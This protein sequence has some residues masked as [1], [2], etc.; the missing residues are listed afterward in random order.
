MWTWHL[1]S[2]SPRTIYCVRTKEPNSPAR[3]GEETRG[4]ARMRSECIL[5]GADQGTDASCLDANGGRVLQRR[6]G[7]VC[8]LLRLCGRCLSGEGVGHDGGGGR[9]KSCVRGE[10]RWTR[11]P[12]PASLAVADAARFLA[13]PIACPP[14]LIVRS[15]TDALLLDLNASDTIDHIVRYESAI[16]ARALGTATDGLRR[17]EWFRLRSLV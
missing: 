7:I 2:G 17:P 1:T 4:T 14:F 15:D 11:L 8:G 13:R 16:I 10:R 3:P 12:A 5:D 9:G 6:L